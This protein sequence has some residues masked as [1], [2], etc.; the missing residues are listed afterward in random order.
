MRHGQ[1]NP[2]G[3]IDHL[4]ELTSKGYQEAKAIGHWF[5][6]SGICLSQ[7]FVSPFIRA[8]QTANTVLGEFSLAVKSQ[9]LDFITPSDNAERF[10]DYLDAVI[11]NN[12]S[13]YTHADHLLIVS[14]MPLVSYLVAELTYDAQSP[15]FQ[16]AAIAHIDYDVTK[17]KGQLVKLFAPADLA[18]I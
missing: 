11:A 12:P 6:D 2:T 16:T 14:H 7:I 15:I 10:H 3:S 13:E 18:A 17:M 1:A 4:R 9:S 8:Q 5:N